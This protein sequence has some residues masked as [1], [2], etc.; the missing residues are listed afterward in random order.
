[1][2]GSLRGCYVATAY[3][4]SFI[5]IKNQPYHQFSISNNAVVCP[6]KPS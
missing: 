5:R 2:R 3:P 4:S 6:W 1:V